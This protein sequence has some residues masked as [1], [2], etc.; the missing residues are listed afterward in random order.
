VAV[1]EARAKSVKLSD[2]AVKLMK[3]GDGKAALALLREL[4]A[5]QPENAW[6]QARIGL[7]LVDAGELEAARASFA[8]QYELGYDRPTAL[9]NTACALALGGD[10]EGAIENIASAVRH[11]FTDTALMT[12]D[13]DLAAVRGDARFQKALADVAMTEELRKELARLEGGDPA[14]FLAVH[15]ELAALLT[16]DG[17]LQAEHG[18][19]AM[20]AGDTK[21]AAEAFGRQARAGLDV[22]TALYNRACARSLAGDAEGALGDLGIAAAKGMAY[23]GMAKD[24][25]LDNVR[26]LAGYAEVQGTIVGR[27]EEGARARALLVSGDAEALAKLV[28]DETRPE[29]IRALAAIALGKLQLADGRFA[30]AE[31]TFAGVAALGIAVDQAA[32]GLAGAMAGLERKDE[33][34]RC[35]QHALELGYADPKALGDLLERH[36]LATPAEAQLLVARAAEMQAKIETRKGYEPKAKAWAAAA[37]PVPTPAVAK[38]S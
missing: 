22:P 33:A 27:A 3:A 13:E 17:K 11:G 30:E 6:A 36:A 28:A 34:L 35:V 15:G 38:G 24:K 2:E 26:K 12:K 29:K 31:T 18:H 8:R 23:E 1:V 9:Y 16:A 37:K 20:K 5:L 10:R 19:L 14:K 21:A 32:F 25:D 7:L 4:V